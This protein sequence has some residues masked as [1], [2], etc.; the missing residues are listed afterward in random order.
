MPTLNIVVGLILASSL[1][2]CASS[3]FDE[4]APSNSSG[5][6]LYQHLCA[7]C[8]GPGG[9]GDGPVGPSLKVPASDLT[10]IAKR[11][12]GTFPTEEVRRSI[13]GRSSPVAHGSREM[14]VWGWRLVNGFNVDEAGERSRV[15][16]VI[17]RLVN[18][19]E[20]IQKP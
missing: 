12:G 14:P 6:E 9:K 11:N 15:D 8:H 1:G 3:G 5:E 19:L 20:S 4:L 13:D 2:G 7:S 18:H 16:K 17:E 10:G